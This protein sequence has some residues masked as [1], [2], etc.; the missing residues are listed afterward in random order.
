VAMV[1]DLTGSYAGALLPVAIMLLVAIIFPLI[2]DK[3]TMREPA[4]Q[5]PAA[6]H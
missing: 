4:Y 6:T 5:P 3:P 1:K 2:S